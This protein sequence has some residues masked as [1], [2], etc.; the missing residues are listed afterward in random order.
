MNVHHFIELSAAIIGISFI[1]KNPSRF[2]ILLLAYLVL[3]FVVDLTGNII[4]LYVSSNNG[5][6]YNIYDVIKHLLLIFLFIMISNRSKK[7]FWPYAGIYCGILIFDITQASTIN[8]FFAFST[9]TADLLLI[10]LSLQFYY[11]LLKNPEYR[12]LL[13]HAY[14]WFANGVFFYFLCVLPYH[15]LWTPMV[16]KELDYDR[17]FYDIII[18]IAIVL[19]YTCLSIAFTVCKY[20]KAK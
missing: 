18:N 6:L 2:F 8:D 20:Q 15:V 12:S 4:Y 11:R 14:F 19:H 10:F 1:R 7:S 16:M 5:W 9:I 13:K 3:S 17:T